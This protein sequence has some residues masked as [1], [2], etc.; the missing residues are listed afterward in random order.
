MILLCWFYQ[1]IYMFEPLLVSPWIVYTVLAGLYSLLVIAPGK[2]GKLGMC[3]TTVLSPI[4]TFG[5]IEVT[6]NAKWQTLSFSTSLINIIILAICIIIIINVF[7]YKKSGYYLVYFT[8][9]LLSVANYYVIQFKKF[10]KRQIL[11]LP[12]N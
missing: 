2:G 11:R 5:I 4:L 8:S 3:L 1:I 10:G 9:F 7:D 12:I 6:S